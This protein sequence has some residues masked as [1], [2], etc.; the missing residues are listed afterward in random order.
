MSQFVRQIPDGDTFERLVCPTCGYVDY[1]NPKVVVGSVVVDAG[2]VLLC[3]R[4]IQPRRG[5]WTLPAGYLEMGETIEDGA[6][7]E[8]LEEA[9]AHIVLDGVLGIY[10][11][12][13]IGQVQVIFRGRFDGPANFATGPE[14][15]DVG[16]FGW[17][18]IP[19]EAIAFPTVRWS[20]QAWHAIGAGPLGAPAATRPKT[21]AAPPAC[22]PTPQRWGRGYEPAWRPCSRAAGTRHGWRHLRRA[23]PGGR[24]RDVDSGP[25]AGQRLAGAR[26]G[27][28][29]VLARRGSCPRQCRTRICSAPPT[30]RRMGRTRRSC[31]ILAARLNAATVKGS[32]KDLPPSTTPDRHLRASPSISLR[33]PLQITGT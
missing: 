6:R 13:R 17:D 28:G 31:R 11:I 30:G 15:Q 26:A 22:P 5:F 29:P 19:W 7:R 9:R 32:C 18:D 12:S 10:S 3:R 16:L 25:A 20:L 33:V 1:E 24:G 27:P 14:S 8:A 23:A 2:R 4:A 21:R